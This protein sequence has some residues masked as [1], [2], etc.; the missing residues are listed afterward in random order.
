MTFEQNYMR[1]L[2]MQRCIYDKL[3][4]YYTFNEHDTHKNNK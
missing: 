1:T 4:N 2:E 3:S